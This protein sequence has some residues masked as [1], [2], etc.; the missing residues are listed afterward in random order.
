MSR[1]RE[2]GKG[3]AKEWGEGR[4]G[5]SGNGHVRCMHRAP[6]TLR[7]ALVQGT[8]WTSRFVQPSVSTAS[9]VSTSYLECSRNDVMRGLLSPCLKSRSK[10]YG[11]GKSLS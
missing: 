11:E 7:L 9:K 5:C 8:S 6:P 3:G 1:E 10:I 2:G 4:R